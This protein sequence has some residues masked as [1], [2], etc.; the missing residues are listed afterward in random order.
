MSAHQSPMDI[1]SN[2]RKESIEVALAKMVEDACDLALIRVLG[3]R[4][5]F[6]SVTKDQV[7]ENTRQADD[8]LKE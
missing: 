8:T 7:G 1:V 6:S 5:T 2:V 3:V 4:L